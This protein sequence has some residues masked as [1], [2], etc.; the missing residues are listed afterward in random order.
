MPYDIRDVIARIVDKGDF[1]EVHQGFARNVVVGVRAA[2]WDGRWRLS[3]ISRR[4][5][6]GALDI[7][8]SR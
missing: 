3:P 4:V 8:A 1:L 7:N 6:A 2:W 5:L